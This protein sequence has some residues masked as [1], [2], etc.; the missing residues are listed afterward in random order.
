M[1]DKTIGEG[2]TREQME[3]VLDEA[4]R[5]VVGFVPVARKEDF[6]RTAG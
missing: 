6:E 4:F 1:N 3:R 2:I 5:K